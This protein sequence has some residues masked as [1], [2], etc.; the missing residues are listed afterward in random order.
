MA[1]AKRFPATLGTAEE[2]LALKPDLVVG[3][4]F[5]APATVQAL[6]QMGFRLEQVGIA[7]TVE[8]SLAQVR[9]LAA[10]AGHPERGELLVGKIEAALSANRAPAGPPISALVWQGGGIVPGDGSL[11]ADLL[12]RTGFANAAAARGLGQADVL[13]LEALLADPPQ[14]IFA[15]GSGAGNENRM[16]HHPALRTLTGTRRES[17][18][19]ALLW[20]GG[21]TI[22]RAAEWLGAVRRGL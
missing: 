13:P 1:V 22:V 6:G 20:C 12:R 18:D 3:S 8:D 11:I 21:S 2:V 17:L 14:L 4:T 16:L 10:L 5:M 19:P 9:R 15:T 7:S